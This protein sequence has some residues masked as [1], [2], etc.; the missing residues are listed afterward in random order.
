VAGPWQSRTATG[1]AASAALIGIGVSGLFEDLTYLP[2]FNLIALLLIAIALTDAGAVRWVAPTRQRL[3]AVGLAA[4]SALLLGGA[5]L[6]NDAGA[7]AYG[8]GIDASVRGDW[9]AATS[10]FETAVAIDPWHPA[11]PDALGISLASLGEPERARTALE[12]AVALAPGNGRAWANLAIVCGA[13]GDDG[14][15]EESG[16]RAVASARLRDAT[17][18]NAAISL[19]G[20]GVTDEA[21]E[22]F[23][24]SLLTNPLTSFSVSWP[25]PVTIG[26]GRI[27]ALGDP[28]SQ[29]GVLIAKMAMGETIWPDAY[30]NAPVRALAMAYLGRDAEARA[31][32]EIAR[33]AAAESPVTWEL[34]LVL[35]RAWGEPLDRSAA[36]YR[37]LTARPISDPGAVVSGD[38]GPLIDIGALRPF[39]R[40]GLVAGA[41]DMR[42]EP[43]YPW[44]LASLLP[45]ASGR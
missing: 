25:R 15:A 5:A 2:G 22:A 7:I 36:I 43:P 39:P 26:D 32:M 31:A 16:R 14:C 17:L 27:E 34:D 23:R 40:G 24:R 6:V 18:I 45:E 3:P 1:R 35:R 19:D 11:G 29:L 4:A 8:A 41:E 28:V 12:R 21:D 37:I 30:P 33:T 42:P 44:V 38:P 10:A 20:V 9:P 13:L